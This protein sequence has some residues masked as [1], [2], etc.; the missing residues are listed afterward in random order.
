M[1]EEHT[2]SVFVG[3][4]RL[5]TDTLKGMLLQTK[6]YL[7]GGEPEPVLIFED[8]TGRQID[9]DFRG[10]PDDVL[11]RLAFHPLFSNTPDQ[12]KSHSGP[13]RPRLGVVC[14][15]V[16]LL[17]R[18]WDWLERQPGGSSASLRR[19]VDEARKRQP[20]KEDVGALRDA[21][22]RFMSVMA[23]NLGHFEEVSR[24]LY[25]G[26]YGHAEPLM[27]DWPVDIRE[28]AARL[29]AR[30]AR[31]ES[32]SAESDTPTHSLPSPKGAPHQ[33]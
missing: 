1:S 12:E 8:H 3:H 10:A 32:R 29:I 20:E 4:C 5:T 28:H 21:A 19:L 33:G 31:A 24:A 25:A 7:D 6:A 18:H 22:G 30:C 9:F 16:S 13:G 14:R 23:G 27:K 15:E 2:Y 11:G 17:P 26:R